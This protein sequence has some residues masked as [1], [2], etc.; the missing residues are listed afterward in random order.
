VIPGTLRSK[1]KSL[2]PIFLVRSCTSNA[3]YHLVSPSWSWSTFFV[4]V[5]VCLYVARPLVS[6]RHLALH[7]RS[8][9]VLHHCLTVDL[10]GCSLGA[11]SAGGRLR[12]S[13]LHP[14]ASLAALSAASFLECPHGR[15]S[16]SLSLAVPCPGVPL[17]VVRCLPECR[18]PIDP[19]PWLRTRWLPGCLCRWRPFAFHLPVLRVLV[20]S[21]VLSLCPAVQRHRLS[22]LC[23]RPYALRGSAV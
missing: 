7:A 15:G 14:V 13:S 9:Y 5:G 23:L 8:V 19:R 10:R 11:A 17:P 21:A 12:P 2:I 20:L 22:R 16:I 4:G 6:A 18:L 3:L 1:R